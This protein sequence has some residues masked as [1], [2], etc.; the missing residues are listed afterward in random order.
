VH[1]QVC[2]FVG[3][4]G[5]GKGSLSAL[6]VKQLDFVQLST[7][8]LCRKHIAEQTTLGKEI[9]FV[10]KSGKLISDRLIVDMIVQWFTE[11]REQV[12]SIILDGFPR[13]VAQAQMFEEFLAGFDPSIQRTIVHLRVPD[14]SLIARVSNRAVC[15]NTSCQAVYSLDASVG[16]APKQEM[17][18]DDCSSPLI[19][20][21]DDE[22]AT[23]YNR[24]LTYHKHTQELFTF[25]E[26]LDTK[27]YEIDG[28]Q[29]L[30]SVF[31]QLNCFLSSERL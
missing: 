22:Q 9:D 24:L 6:C 21:S 20:R 4:P 29:P 16:L 14:K 17:I 19:K 30:N 10:I 12:H 5:S 8:N 31:D 2:I 27:I 11:H 25:Y 13:T 26:Q 15:Q 1:K 28:E 18:C 3:P 23:M 7:G